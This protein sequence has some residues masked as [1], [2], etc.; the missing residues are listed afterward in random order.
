M[1]KQPVRRRFKLDTR[2]GEWKVLDRDDELSFTIVCES[3]DIAAEV[4]ERLERDEAKRVRQ[5][6]RNAAQ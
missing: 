5:E 3:V 1:S 4:V 2:E 6:H